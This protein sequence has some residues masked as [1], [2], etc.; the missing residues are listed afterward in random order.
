MLKVKPGDLVDFYST[1][2]A[3]QR[4]YKNR[5]PGLVL[6]TKLIGS[7][8]KNKPVATVMWSDGSLTNEYTQ[9]LKQ[10]E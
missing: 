10:V 2:W 7:Y 8:D 4:E 6:H 9:F 5:N 1:F 3:F